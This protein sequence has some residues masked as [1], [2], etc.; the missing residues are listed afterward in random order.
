M[1]NRDRLPR[2]ETLDEGK[3]VDYRIFT[4]QGMVRRSPRT[5]RSGTYQVLHI[6]AWVNV[7]AL[8]PD[9]EIVMVEQYRHGIDTITLEM[10]GGVVEPGEDP[11]ETASRELLEETG[12]SGETPIRIGL[13]HPNPAIQDNECSTWLIRNAR[14]TA[15]PTPDE[16]EHISVHT[17]ARTEIP[18]LLRQGQITHSLM[19]AAFHWLD[20]T[21]LS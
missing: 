21:T 9:D 10:P 12:Y 18:A 6:A 7:I 8:T 3:I 15:E 14:R 2:W 17:V 5:G 20:L 19:V 1:K 11:A 4:V 16:G 13:V